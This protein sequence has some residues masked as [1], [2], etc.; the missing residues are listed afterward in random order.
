MPTKLGHVQI[1]VRNSITTQ[2]AAR[3]CVKQPGSFST[4]VVRPFSRMN[5]VV[6]NEIRPPAEGFPT[7]GALVRVGWVVHLLGGASEQTCG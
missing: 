4:S 1:Q 6:S 3:C 5:F 2:G 7:F